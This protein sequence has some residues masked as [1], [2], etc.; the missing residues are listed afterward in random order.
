MNDENNNDKNPWDIEEESVKKNNSSKN[1]R[2]NESKKPE[3]IFSYFVENLQSNLSKKNSSSGGGSNN[4]NVFPPSI[5]YIIAGFS[6][7]LWIVS[8]FYLVQEGEVAVVLRFG[9]MVRTSTNAGLHY[10]LP[11]PIEQEIIRNVVEVHQIDSTATNNLENDQNLI[12][13]GDE[14][15]VLTDYTVQWNIKD[16][17]QYLFVLRNPE[18]TIRAASE[19]ALREVV[20]Q[21]TARLA[22]TEGREEIGIKT[23]A[24]LQKILDFYNSGVSVISFKL[25]KVEPPAQVV[26]AFNDM[27]ASRV[28]A[29]RLSNEAQSYSNDILP[30]ARG[31]AESI[32][33]GAEAYSAEVIAKVEGEAARFSKIYNSYKKDPTVARIRMHRETM[34]S[35][36]KNSNTTVVDKE[37]SSTLQNYN[38]IIPPRILNK[39][40]G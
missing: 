28:D 2:K 37:L 7:F 32:M 24:L 9:E 17:N 19:S 11:Q 39:K 38:Q 3:N 5:V 12:L 25:Q 1:S 16:L 40:E 13:T 15:M 20:G 8:G 6:L 34:E 29:D 22:L 36:L 33:R 21:T 18:L 27:Q 4:G 31:Q 14:N 10:R 35:L 23:Q 30:K 26:D